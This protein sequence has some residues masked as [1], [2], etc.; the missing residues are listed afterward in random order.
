MKRNVS[1]DTEMLCWKNKFNSSFAA[2]YVIDI[3]V[4]MHRNAKSCFQVFWIHSVVR[5]QFTQAQTSKWQASNIVREIPN[6]FILFA[7]DAKHI[8]RVDSHFVF[9]SYWPVRDEL[10]KNRH[11]YLS[12]LFA[13]DSGQQ[14]F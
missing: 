12:C 8:H 7:K 4:K 13:I 2:H 6:N 5:A 3:A 11:K 1:R 9:F 10:Y 14:H